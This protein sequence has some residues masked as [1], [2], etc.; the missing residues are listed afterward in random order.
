MAYDVFE[1]FHLDAKEDAYTYCLKE[2][3]QDEG[4]RERCASFFDFNDGNYECF[5]GTISLEKESKGGRIKKIIPDLILFNKS[6]IAV[7]ES[8]MYASEG[9]RQM[10]DYV[11]KKDDIISKVTG[12]TNLDDY[13]K[14]GVEYYYFTLKGSEVNDSEVKSIKW[15]DFYLKTLRDYKS[16]NPLRKFLA[17]EI[18]KRAEE[19]NDI[20]GNVSERTYIEI[21]NNENSWIT[22]DSLFSAGAIDKVWKINNDY[23]YFNHIIQGVGHQT[24]ATDFYKDEWKIRG[25]C[26]LDNIY[27][28]IRV[29]WN[30]NSIDIFLNWE[31]WEVKEEWEDY[32]PY[33]KMENS[34]KDLAQKFHEN[35]DNW[36]EDVTEN[37][38][39]KKNEYNIQ[40]T[41]RKTNRLHILK[42]SIDSKDKVIKNLIEEIESYIRLFSEYAD[43]ISENLKKNKDK[44][45]YLTYVQTH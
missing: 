7:V 33:K 28:F 13:E 10:A 34:N 37:V 3:L 41:S 23:K 30:Y 6:R 42:T 8:K 31:Y 38:E 2:L 22:P 43:G 14:V 18:L 17:S 44:Y 40:F 4:Y 36:Q 5:R 19:Y 20:L 9:W 27:L 29:E 35:K 11:E 15:V 45:D 21:V 32:I 12:K 26:E 39:E 24:V 25:N 16:T 1:L